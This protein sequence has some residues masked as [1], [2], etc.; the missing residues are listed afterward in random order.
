MRAFDVA[1][2]DPI[3]A[4][5]AGR[6]ASALFELATEQNQTSE[7][8]RDLTAFQ[9]LIDESADLLRLVRSPIFSADD[10]LKAIKAI[11]EKAGVSALTANFLQVIARNRRLF[12]LPDMIKA[13]RQMA[14]QARGEVDA[15]VA[16]A[17]ELSEQQL[18]KLSDTLKAA[19]G[20]DVRIHTRVDP[21]LL[22]GLVVKVGSRMIDNS[23][24]TKLNSLKTRMKEVS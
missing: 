16:S 6:Y 17:V 8:E 21:S 14:A 4:S 19:V 24:A 13:Y 23:L 20:K 12:A 2:D 3:M 5:V 1:T 10:Q 7:V 18:T 15:D 11:V 22:G 9:A